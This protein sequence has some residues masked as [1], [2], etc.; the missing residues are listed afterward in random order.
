MREEATVMFWNEHDAGGWVWFAMSAGMLLFW[1]LVGVIA[2]LSFR[3]M[4]RPERTAPPRAAAPETILDERFARGDIDEDEYGR[5]RAV[6]AARHAGSV[7]DAAG[8]GDRLRK[9]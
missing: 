7:T 5:R 8:E 4:S 3:A 6:L 9:R 2:V 1:L